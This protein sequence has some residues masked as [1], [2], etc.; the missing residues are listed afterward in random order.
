MAPRPEKQ[1]LQTKLEATP[2]VV[3]R[4]ERKKLLVPPCV[5]EDLQEPWRQ[6]QE[7]A[8]TKKIRTDIGMSSYRSN[9]EETGDEDVFQEAR[10]ST[11]TSKRGGANRPGKNSFKNKN[12]LRGDIEEL[13]GNVYTYGRR[14]QGDYYIK[15]TEAI[16]E[17]VGREYSKE[18]RLL[19]KDKMETTFTEPVEPLS[20]KSKYAIEK[21]KQELS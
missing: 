21:Y 8:E 14:D 9:T 6:H 5:S 1:D 4:P 20:D 17:Y 2:R 15:T 13:G 18:M 10:Q 11:R 16:A 3:P 7:A 19:V 12:N